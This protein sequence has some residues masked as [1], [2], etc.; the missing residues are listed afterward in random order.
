MKTGYGHW[1][2]TIEYYGKEISSTTT[3]S[4]A[5]DDYNC[6]EWEKDGRELRKNRGYNSLR[7]EIIRKHK[8]AQ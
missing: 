2:I 4:M 8:E 5:V 3:N 7:N 6:E 1:R